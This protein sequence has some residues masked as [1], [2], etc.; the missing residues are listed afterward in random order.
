MKM[1][2]PCCGMMMYDNIDV[3]ERRQE[4]CCW[5]QQ[6]LV[7]ATLMV[8]VIETE[9]PACGN[10]DGNWKQKGPGRW[11][12]THFCGISILLFCFFVDDFCLWSLHGLKHLKPVSQIFTVHS[13][14]WGSPSGALSLLSGLWLCLCSHES[15]HLL[16]NHL[17]VWGTLCSILL[18][19]L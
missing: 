3:L 11:R 13:I 14:W 10:F 7:V 19:N 18:N 5:R 15:F 17:N 4:R 16:E 8:L 9:R 1:H 12:W 6:G 2:L